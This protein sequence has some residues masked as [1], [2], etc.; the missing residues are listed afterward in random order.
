[1]DEFDDAM[2]AAAM[3]IGQQKRMISGIVI[4]CLAD[5]GLSAPKPERRERLTIT[6][7]LDYLNQCAIPLTRAGIYKMRS[8]G[9]IPAVR[10][11][12]RLIFNR[13]E[14]DAWISSREQSKTSRTTATQNLAR[15]A[16]R[17]RP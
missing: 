6:E 12:K 11:G 10:V 7:T 14:L 4:K 9:T 15:S 3:S 13:S 2:P 1:M 16:G 5:F 17:K 8:E